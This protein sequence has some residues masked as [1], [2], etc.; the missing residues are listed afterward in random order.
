MSAGGWISFLLMAQLA[1][2]TALSVTGDLAVTKLV[3]TV[4]VPGQCQ[5]NG[6][7]LVFNLSNGPE[8][9]SVT[10]QNGASFDL[11]RQAQLTSLGN[12]GM[13]GNFPQSEQ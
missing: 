3:N 9:F 10:P 5:F 7:G 2:A 1:L 12:G 13:A 8:D 4:R 11:V 6:T